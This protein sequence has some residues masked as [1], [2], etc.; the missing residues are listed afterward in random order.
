[1][2]YLL[3]VYGLCNRMRALDSA[4]HLAKRTNH[5]LKVYWV[6]NEQLGCRFSDLFEPIWEV[7]IL[8]KKQTPFIWQ[9]GHKFNLYTPDLFRRTF[10][11]RVWNQFET[12]RKLE[13]GFDFEEFAW[14]HQWFALKSFSDFLK[15]ENK[16]TDFK[17]IKELRDR[18]KLQTQLI[19]N[20]TIGV[21][22]RRTDHSQSKEFSPLYLFEERMKKYVVSNP[23][24]NFYLATDCLDTKD[25]LAN[26]FKGRVVTDWSEQTRVTKNGMQHALVEL[27]TLAQTSKIIGSFFSSFTRT[28]S[29]INNIPLEI[30]KK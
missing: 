14:S 20:N 25:Y 13:E 16:Y 30:L 2:I 24:T 12:G 5:Q 19:N 6:E 9:K 28:A 26:H 29:Q 27:Y 10:K 23:K 11:D 22:I 1:M 18:I 4:I 7:E 3:P 17:P 8:E 21:H 15:N